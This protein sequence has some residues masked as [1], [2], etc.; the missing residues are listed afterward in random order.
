M[1]VLGAKAKAA[2]IEL[3]G[4]ADL[5]LVSGKDPQ[6]E[7][8]GE[9]AADPRFDGTAKN[10]SL[11]TPTDI[12]VTADGN[13][14]YTAAFGS[15]KIGVFN[16]GALEND[17]FNPTSISTNYISVTGGGPSGLA[18]DEPRGL[19]YVFTRFDNSVKVV[20]LSTRQ[21]L[22]SVAF[23]NPEPPSVTAGAASV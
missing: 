12:A 16:T 20:N 21:E 8:K 4:A 14:L 23:P 7:L 15:S 6:W 13:T 1:A 9:L 3:D 22:Y 18:L 5:F 17:S 2:G 19:L 11:A 10:H